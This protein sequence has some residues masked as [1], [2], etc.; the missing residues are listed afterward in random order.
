MAHFALVHGRPASPSH[1]RF[2]Y[3]STGRFSENASKPHAEVIQRCVSGGR[4]RLA[5]AHGVPVTGR[6]M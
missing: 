3:T 2:T 4:A 1:D 5:A 6:G